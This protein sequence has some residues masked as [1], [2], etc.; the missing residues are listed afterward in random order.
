MVHPHSAP[1]CPNCRLHWR[2]L[3]PLR[4]ASVINHHGRTKRRLPSDLRVSSTMPQKSKLW[5][6]DW[7]TRRHRSNLPHK[8]SAT[9]ATSNMPV[10]SSP[11]SLSILNLSFLTL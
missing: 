11:P 5:T 3:Q 7:C 9:V 8:H 2:R 4:D 6:T 10:T 1:L